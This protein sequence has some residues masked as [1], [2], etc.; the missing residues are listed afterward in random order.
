M[1]DLLLIALPR[2]GGRK[3]WLTEFAVAKEHDE[4]K[5]YWILKSSLF[6]QDA[7]KKIIY[8]GQSTFYLSNYSRPGQNR[9]VHSPTDSEAGGS[10]LYLALL[11]V[12]HKILPG[13]W[14]YKRR[15]KILIFFIFWCS[16]KVG[17]INAT[18]P[19]KDLKKRAKNETINP[20][21]PETFW[22]F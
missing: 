8:I 18:F 22:T 1:L 7:W 6:L 21:K 13:I 14:Q 9:P 5:F 3:I 15:I 10:R 2:Y 12:L 17:W 4:V 19:F 11:L 20:I 16:K